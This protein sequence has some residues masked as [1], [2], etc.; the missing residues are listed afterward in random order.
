MKRRMFVRNLTAMGAL[1]V[2][3]SGNLFSRRPY[4]E[5][6]LEGEGFQFKYRT[7][8]VSHIPE[9][10]TFMNGLKDS[11]KLSNNPTY[12]KY[13][14]GMKFHVPPSFP[15]AK[16]IIVVAI[17]QNITR[18][19]F[20]LH[21]EVRPVPVAP[22]YVDNG[23]SMKTIQDVVRTKII[24][25]P[26]ARL[27]RARIPQKMAAVRSGLAKYGK[28]NISFVEGMGSYHQLLTFYS[29]Y[30]FKNDCWGRLK[31]LPECKGCFI[32]MKEC[33]SKVIRKDNFVIDV[34]RCVTLYNELTDPM[35]EWMPA[36][37][38][39]SLIGC[40]ACQYPCPVNIPY[41][42]H[43][44][45]LPDITEDE[46]RMVLSGKEDKK[47]WDSV[48]RKLNPVGGSNNLSYL[49]KNLNLVIHNTTKYLST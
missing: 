15:E 6:M 40:L 8:S 25:D 34:G 35:P 41:N 43:V 27:E 21:G 11:G 14:G 19:N 28:N 18:L 38:H 42:N 26:D 4:D 33:R 9:M 17:P 30:P 23:I 7:V 45:T 16:F 2:L 10:E 47:L 24:G 31:M 44:A 20:Q 5:T 13:L 36:E 12:R 29:D 49:S 1:S 48:R 32:C 37:S 39:N 3:S 22:G 46:T